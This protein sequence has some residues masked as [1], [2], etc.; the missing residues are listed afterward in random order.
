VVTN[1]PKLPDNEDDPTMSNETHVYLIIRQPETNYAV[2]VGQNYRPSQ[3]D[4]QRLS[5]MGY[6]PGVTDVNATAALEPF[7]STQEGLKPRVLMYAS[8]YPKLDLET[9]IICLVEA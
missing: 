3:A 4:C 2:I 5:R 1:E 8:L 7:P 6:L 9:A